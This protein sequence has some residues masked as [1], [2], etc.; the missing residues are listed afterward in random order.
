[1]DKEQARDLSALKVLYV[2]DEP[3]IR[4]ALGRFLRRRVNTLLEAADGQ[5]GLALFEKERPDL[6]I[7]DIR[8]P[9]MSGLE[10][11]EA[12]REID[13]D[14]PIIITTAFNDESYFI[15]AIDLGIDKFLKKPIENVQLSEALG[16]VARMTLQQRQLEEKNRLIS[17]ILDNISELVMI[18]REGEVSFLNRAFLAFAKAN[19]IEAFGEQ[20]GIDRLLLDKDDAFYKE[21]SFEEWLQE[22]CANPD[23]EYIVHMVPPGGLKSQPGAFM[24]RANHI[25]DQTGI[26]A[27]FIDVTGLER[28]R[29]RISKIAITDPLTEIYNRKKFT[30]ELERELQRSLRYRQKLSLIIFD[31]DHFKEVND[32]YGHQVGDTVLQELTQLVREH[33]R[34]SDLFARYGG[35]EFVVLLPESDLQGACVLAEKLREEIEAFDFSHVAGITC[36]FGVSQYGEEEDSEN[37]IRR[38]DEALYRA[39]N[40]GRNRVESG[41]I[42][43]ECKEKQ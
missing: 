6:V 40:S 42:V 4:E 29:E 18:E 32:T 20:G 36:S 8:M 19:S 21:R 10:M 39:K 12:I 15:R 14:V 22:V 43:T 31:I 35:E 17:A 9:Q 3:V 5:E 2:E 25:S 16:R 13:R 38:A 26:L 30:D 34:K 33:I 7:T 23:R 41:E 37:F 11:A 1:M 27:T 24:V 28:E